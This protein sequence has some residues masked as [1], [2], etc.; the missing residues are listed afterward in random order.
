MNRR[1]TKLE[2]LFTVRRSMQDPHT[3]QTEKPQTNKKNQNKSQRKANKQ[4]EEIMTGKEWQHLFTSEKNKVLSIIALM[5]YSDWVVRLT[6]ENYNS[7]GRRKKKKEMC[8][9]SIVFE[10]AGCDH[11]GLLDIIFF[12]LKACS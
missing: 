1:Q 12:N 7:K 10:A 2:S 3:N 11:S 9:K 4:E 8:N 5:N 6:V